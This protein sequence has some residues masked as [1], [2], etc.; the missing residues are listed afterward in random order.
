MGN[1][2]RRIANVLTAIH[3]ELFGV[4]RVQPQCRWYYDGN[5]DIYHCPHTAVFGKDVMARIPDE[6]YMGHSP[7][8]EAWE[9]TPESDAHPL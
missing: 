5:T 7:A 2:D 8:V 9:E 3:R 6:A 4:R 1:I